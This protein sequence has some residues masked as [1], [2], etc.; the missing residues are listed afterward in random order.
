MVDTSIQEQQLP[1]NM[2]SDK[3]IISQ[4]YT[5]S[6]F[7]QRSA[8][9]AITLIYVLSTLSYYKERPIPNIQSIVSN[10]LQSRR[11]DKLVRTV[12]F[13]GDYCF[14]LLDRIN[15]GEKISQ[16][17]ILQSSEKERQQDSQQ[18]LESYILLYND[19]R[20]H[21]R[22]EVSCLLSSFLWH[23]SGLFLI[24]SSCA[25]GLL[26]GSMQQ[27]R[28]S[29]NLALLMKRIGDVRDQTGKD[30]N[31]EE[32]EQEELKRKVQQKQE[33]IDPEKKIGVI[34]KLKGLFKGRQA[35]AQSQGQAPEQPKKKQNIF[36]SALS[37]IRNPSKAK[38]GKKISQFGQFNPYDIQCQIRKEIIVHVYLECIRHIYITPITIKEGQITYPNQIF[39]IKDTQQSSNDNQTSQ[40]PS[41]PQIIPKQ[42]IHLPVPPQSS[43]FTSLITVTGEEIDEISKIPR[44]LLKLIHMLVNKRFDAEITN[45]IF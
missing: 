18:K 40:D 35:Q 45:D 44:I 31:T 27:A 5:K 14:K 33:E 11:G 25:G 10:S 39:N 42:S 24:S 15:Q 13:A 12:M 23:T 37:T 28:I 1:Q 38:V 7:L 36:L 9:P 20:E 8:H 16:N 30:I 32:E 3:E 41:N 17:Q 26:E 43:P 34:N 2:I 19:E 6:S 4:S 21:E 29:V 22:H